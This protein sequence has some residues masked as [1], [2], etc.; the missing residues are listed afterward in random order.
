MDIL[1]RAARNARIL[2]ESWLSRMGF[3]SVR[4]EFRGPGGRK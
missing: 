1:E 2:V 4:V 3:A